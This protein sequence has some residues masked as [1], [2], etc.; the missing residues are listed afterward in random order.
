[1]KIEF[2]I[3]P[4]SRIRFLIILIAISLIF[5]LV[6]W[7]RLRLSS[8]LPVD[9][10]LALKSLSSLFYLISVTPIF[11]FRLLDLCQKWKIVWLLPMWISYILSTENYLL[12]NDFLGIRID[13]LS[14]Q[15]II[16]G[17]LA[18]IVFIYLLF[19]QSTPA[20]EFTDE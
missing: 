19:A 17:I 20:G 18:V 4:L 9:K 5:V 12:I 11:Y 2:R 6:N 13:P 10:Y 15:S 16:I 7:A 3:K 14:I 1:L 8:G